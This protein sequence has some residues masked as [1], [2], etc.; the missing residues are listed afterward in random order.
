MT[1][2]SKISSLQFGILVFLYTI[3]ST[4]LLAPSGLAGLAKQ[5][6]WIASIVGVGIGG[7]CVV[8]Y[9][10]LGNLFPN[11]TFVEYCEKILGKWVGK[12]I[13]ITFVFFFFIG[14]TTV[15]FHMGNFLV[16]QI[17]PDTPI[18][19][20]NAL[21]AVIIV[22]GIRL[23]IEVFAR[24]A[25]IFFPW[26]VLLFCI[27]LF[28]LLPEIEIKNIQPVFEEGIKPICVGAL[29]L[30]SVASL[31]CIVFTMIIPCVSEINKVRT[32]FII[33][34]YIGGFVIITTTFLC[35][36]VL[37]ADFTAR[38]TFPSYVLAKK[39]SIGNF[40]ERIEILIAILWFIT[41]FY[42]ILLYFYA[43]IIGTAQI[44]G[45]KDFRPITLPFGMILV[46]YSY[47]VYP[48][49]V[50]AAEWDTTVWIPYALTYGFFLPL[51]LF[52]VAKIRF[53]SNDPT[54]NKSM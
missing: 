47:I 36:A 2:N 4:I 10:K 17:M 49:T 32:T 7:I 8:L 54:N 16:T 24:A 38:S 14:A 5:D 53:K 21:F 6:A 43:C 27:L 26:V 18:H 23:G 13:S 42:K 15:L 29:S 35:I 45:L 50:Y 40:V 31:P 51:L 39:I 48:N 44:L 20:I 37:G 22:Y 12:I 46:I 30:V 52:V 25:E 34:L 41:I 1:S 19:I 9:S 3:G 11:I 28:T 33:S